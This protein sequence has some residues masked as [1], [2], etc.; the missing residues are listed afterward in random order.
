MTDL[1]NF[2]QAIAIG[3][4][5]GFERK[6][7]AEQPVF[8]KLRDDFSSLV[9]TPSLFLKRNNSSAFDMSETICTESA[10][11]ADTADT[12]VV[13]TCAVAG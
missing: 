1:F 9:A 13:V 12:L 8:S 10:E 5:F 3:Q 2:S 11:T 4:Q 6:G 7:Q